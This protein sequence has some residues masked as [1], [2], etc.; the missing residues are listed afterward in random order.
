MLFIKT[1]AGS[2]LSRWMRERSG[3]Y[4][5]W[6]RSQCSPVCLA[7]VHYPQFT[8]RKQRQ[9]CDVI[10]FFD[11]SFIFYVVIF[12]EEDFV[13]HCN[14]YGKTGFCRRFFYHFVQKWCLFFDLQREIWWFYMTIDASVLLGFCKSFTT[15]LCQK[16]D[17]RRFHEWTHN[18]VQCKQIYTS[19][20]T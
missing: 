5:E 11:K 6:T 10:F 4:R 9:K 15:G 8:W 18:S 17:K 13:I 2:C 12:T 3:G 14:Q 19:I 1:T 16:A 7:W 20:C